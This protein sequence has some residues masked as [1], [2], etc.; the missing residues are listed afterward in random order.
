MINDIT[1]YSLEFDFLQFKDSEK[2]DTREENFMQMPRNL[3]N[4]DGKPKNV[5]ESSIGP[6]D[7]VTKVQNK[8]FE[9]GIPT[10]T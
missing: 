9:T 7:L 10:T 5:E 8:Y 3:P 4:S 6:Q 2:P 1:N